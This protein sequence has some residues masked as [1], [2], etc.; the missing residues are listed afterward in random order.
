VRSFRSSAH[1]VA[2]MDEKPSRIRADRISRVVNWLACFR[3]VMSLPVRMF[4]MSCSI[5]FMRRI[6]IIMHSRSNV[7]LIYFQ[8]DD[9]AP[10]S[11]DQEPGSELRLDPLP[12]V[13]GQPSLEV[14]PAGSRAGQDVELSFDSGDRSSVRRCEFNYG[15]Q[16]VGCGVGYD[17]VFHFRL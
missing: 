13:R 8:A 6:C 17:F 5:V 16:V 9:L 2:S 15:Q 10:D 3:A 12:G 7:F 4:S 11:V 14:L 1:W